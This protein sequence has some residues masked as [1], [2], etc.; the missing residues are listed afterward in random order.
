MREKPYDRRDPLIERPECS[1]RTMA[2]HGQWPRPNQGTDSITIRRRKCRKLEQL[3]KNQKA[4]LAQKDEQITSSHLDRVSKFRLHF[5][6]RSIIAIVSS[7]LL[8]RLLEGHHVEE[9]HEGERGEEDGHDVADD[10]ATVL[11]GHAGSHVSSGAA[12]DLGTKNNKERGIW[13]FIYICPSADVCFALR[14]E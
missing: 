1:T 14:L 8:Q 5:L 6:D 9:R 13:S 4:F 12:A 3:S 10:D 2:V 7:P 11:C